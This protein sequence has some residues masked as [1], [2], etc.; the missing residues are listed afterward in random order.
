MKPARAD[1]A[2]LIPEL[3]T[4]AALRERCAQMQAAATYLGLGFR[5]ARLSPEM[6]GR[7]LAHLRGNVARFRSERAI[8]EIGSADRTVIP[9]LLFEDQAFNA[10]LGEELRPL[11]EA[12]AGVPLELSACY[13]IRCY[14]RGAFLHN[15]VDRPTHVVSATICVDH[16][17][18]ARWPLHIE[19]IDGEV[20]QVDIDPGEFVLYEGARLAHGRP[21]PLQGEFYASVFVHFRPAGGA[22]QGTGR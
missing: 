10:R 4:P 20:S 1:A 7:L 15:H 2:A 12:W 13:G 5:K 6:H 8:E 19:S 3:A 9:A 22:A 17:L 14:Q 18:D 21:Y 11:H 16:A